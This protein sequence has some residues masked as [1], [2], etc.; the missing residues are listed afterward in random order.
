MNV[1]VSDTVWIVN[2]R[3]KSERYSPLDCRTSAPQRFFLTQ[4]RILHQNSEKRQ[5]FVTLGNDIMMRC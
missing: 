3:N 5:E 4:W 2:K 1:V